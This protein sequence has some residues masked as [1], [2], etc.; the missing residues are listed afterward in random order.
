[1]KTK[2]VLPKLICLVVAALALCLPVQAKLTAPKPS[3]SQGKYASYVL[4]KWS[5]VSGAKYGYEVYRGT[6][7]KFS[8]ASYLSWVKSESS[9]SYKD[10]SAKSGKTYYYWVLPVD[11]NYIAWYKSSRYA[12]GY[13]KK[14]SPSSSSGIVGSSSVF[15]GST[16]TLNFKYNNS[17]KAPTRWWLSNNNKAYFANDYFAY[18]LYEPNATIRGWDAGTTT[19]YAEYN[20][21]TYSKKITVK[22]KPF[23]GI[24][25]ASSLKA[26]KSANY[27]LYLNDKKVTSKSVKWSRSGL[28]TMSD[29]GYY[30]Q[31]KAT[32]RPVTTHKVTVIAQYNGKKYTKIVTITR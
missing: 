6:S 2:T 9:T 18:Y 10:T 16:I 25:G 26:G 32:S 14:T 21:K 23:I 17:Y 1:M 31:L 13:L 20:G 29:K 24:S 19:I 22:T 28:A 15:V 27:Y 30:G 11:K 8:K 3:A 5:K 7:T 4:V 12:K